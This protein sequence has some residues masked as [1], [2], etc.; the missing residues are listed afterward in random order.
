MFIYKEHLPLPA[1]MDGS[2]T[3]TPSPPKTNWKKGMIYLFIFAVVVSVTAVGMS[4][5]STTPIK[6]TLSELASTKAEAARQ[7]QEAQGEVD[8]LEA[9]DKDGSL[10]QGTT[11]GKQ[12]ELLSRDDYNDHKWIDSKTGKHFAVYNY[13]TLTK[14]Q[15]DLL[16]EK[17]SGLSPSQL[18]C[19]QGSTGDCKMDTTST[20]RS[21][22]ILDPHSTRKRQSIWDQMRKQA[23]M[24]PAQRKK[25]QAKG[26]PVFDADAVWGGDRDRRN[27]HSWRCSGWNGKGTN[28]NGVT[29]A[30]YWARALTN[31]QKAF[32]NNKHP[33]WKAKDYACTDGCN[34][35]CVPDKGALRQSFFPGLG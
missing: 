17:F 19:V 28:T 26:S 22:R 27:D 6:N 4:S 2:P 35:S 31:P 3:T 23:Q 30:F 14:A 34:G 1:P 32:V 15:Q 8:M 18:G 24:T 5:S 7:Q 10:K 9:F 20:V 16:G 13:D 11:A 21:W 25:E 12:T 33:N 29:Y